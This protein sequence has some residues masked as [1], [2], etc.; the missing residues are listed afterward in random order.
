VA[1]KDSKNY[2]VT[3]S[4]SESVYGEEHLLRSIFESLFAVINAEVSDKSNLSSG[5]E[6]LKKGER[7]IA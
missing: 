1:T 2:I 3:T 4:P 6:E 7:T 5:T